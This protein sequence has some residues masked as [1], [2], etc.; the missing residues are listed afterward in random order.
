MIIAI[1]NQA[2]SGGG[3]LLANNLAV[4]RARSGHK[5]LLLDTDPK[6]PSCAW[7]CARA[8]ADIRPRIPARAIGRT[9]PLPAVAELLL[10]YND[11][12]VDAAHDTLQSHAA[13]SVAR[14][15][16]VPVSAQQVDLAMQYQLIGRL[17]AVRAGNPRL[18]VLFVIVSGQDDPP[19]D[20][21]AAVRAYVARVMFAT[22]ATTI[23]HAPPTHDY[24]EGRCVCDAETCDPEMAGEMHALYREVYALAHW[25]A[26]ASTGSLH[27]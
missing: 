14:L 20:A 21:L 16:L 8:S 18:R 6:Q 1:A 3:A 23:V 17:N 11:M 9:K 5:V 19:G 15:V 22:L 2:G 7:S 25:P 10:H 4:L 27:P 26:H 12:L 13:L 24:G